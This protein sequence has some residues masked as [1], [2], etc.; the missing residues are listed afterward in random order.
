MQLTHSQL[1]APSF[2]YSYPYS[3]SFPTNNPAPIPT[4]H[5]SAHPPPPPPSTPPLPP[6]C[7]ANDFQ[8]EAPAELEVGWSCP[9]SVSSVDMRWCMLSSR[10]LN[11]P[12]HSWGT[13][14][15][16]MGLSG[17]PASAGLN[18]TT[19]PSL[20]FPPPLPTQ[21]LPFPRLLSPHS[22]ST[23]KMWPCSRPR[24]PLRKL[25]YVIRSPPLLLYPPAAVP[26]LNPH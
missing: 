7:W 12:A 10:V 8:G 25:D 14:G 20:R 17:D 19:S 16:G 6:T 4:P 1:D 3:D 21:A 5:P 23:Y 11:E 18:T 9:S 13:A 2:S 22:T 26:T 15:R 24:P